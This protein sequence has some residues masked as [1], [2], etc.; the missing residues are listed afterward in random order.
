[1]EE[2]HTLGK[3]PIE[4]MKEMYR[5]YKRVR[6]NLDHRFRRRNVGGGGGG[7]SDSTNGWF[8]LSDVAANPMT[9]KLQ[10]CSA[11]SFSDAPGATDQS[12]YIHPGSQLANY[13]VDAY[14]FANYV[15]DCWV[16]V[17][18]FSSDDEIVPTLFEVCS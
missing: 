13:A 18:I 6:G 9:G 3:R 11:G 2:L 16:S 12:I 5:W 15:G 1:M 10:T 14:V 7:D 8:K 4:Q 17:N